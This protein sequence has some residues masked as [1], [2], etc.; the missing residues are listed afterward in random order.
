LRQF[1]VFLSMTVL[2]LYAER[3]GLELISL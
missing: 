2:Y 1:C 3:V